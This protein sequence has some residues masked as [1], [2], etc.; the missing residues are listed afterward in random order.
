MRGI[1]FR[2]EDWLTT[3]E[4]RMSYAEVLHEELARELRE[5]GLE[6][7]DR[8]LRLAVAEL[9]R[10]LGDRGYSL[11]LE[12]RDGKGKTR[13]HFG[14]SPD[15]PTLECMV[16]RGGVGVAGSGRSLEGLPRSRLA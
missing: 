9:A 8:P 15:E 11:V 14:F 3:P 7:G 16:G 12:V 1:P 10:P 6:A 5:L 2:L 13:L 4:D